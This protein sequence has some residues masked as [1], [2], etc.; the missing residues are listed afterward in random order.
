MATTLF[1][2][3]LALHTALLRG[4]GAARRAA[5]PHAQFGD[6]DEVREAAAREA[7]EREPLAGAGGSGAGWADWSADEE[8]NDVAA[9]SWADDDEASFGDLAQGGE[10]AVEPTWMAPAAPEPSRPRR[11]IETVKIGRVSGP[12]IRRNGYHVDLRVQHKDAEVAETRHTL[13][14]SHQVRFFFQHTAP[15]LA[16]LRLTASAAIPLQVLDETS[17]MRGKHEEDLPVSDFAEAVLAFLGSEGGVDLA[18][19]DWE[20]DNPDI[21]FSSQHFSV[22]SL[23]F[24]YPQLKEHLATALLGPDTGAKRP[25]GFKNMEVG[26]HPLSGW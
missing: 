17:I 15:S 9:P 23:F 18:D 10:A 13:W 16:T 22:R 20:L 5:A 2:A 8:N 21:P 1:C 14:I 3:A 4:P 7:V 24:Y 25:P 19:E 6:A 26:S 11:P 12:Y